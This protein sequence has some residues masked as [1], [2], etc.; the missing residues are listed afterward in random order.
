MCSDIEGNLLSDA[1]CSQY[2][3]LKLVP[4]KHKLEKAIYLAPGV[5]SARY[6]G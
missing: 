5:Y 6:S 3:G 1:V 2:M 4:L